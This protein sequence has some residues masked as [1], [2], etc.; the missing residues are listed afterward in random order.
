MDSSAPHS[1]NIL[2]FLK[3]FIQ[4]QT[5]DLTGT[6]KALFCTALSAADSE[7]HSFLSCTRREC[8]FPAAENPE[9]RVEMPSITDNLQSGIKQATRRKTHQRPGTAPCHQLQLS[10]SFNSKGFRRAC[11]K[12]LQEVSM[13]RTCK[14]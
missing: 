2:Q 1:K 11:L 10:F 4:G 7:P 13:T 5:S 6:Q 12:P 3:A 8:I 14:Q 9:V